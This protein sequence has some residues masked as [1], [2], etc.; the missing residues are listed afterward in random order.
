MFSL[1]DMCNCVGYFKVSCQVV[2]TVPKLSGSVTGIA[3]LNDRM[4]VSHNVDGQIA[5][6]CPAN[7]QF[8]QY[9]NCYCSSCRKRSGYI[10]QCCYPLYG[11]GYTLELQHV[12]A[13]D[14]N[15][16]LYISIQ[17]RYNGNRICKVAVDQNNKLFC[18]FVHGTIPQCLSVTSSG[19]VLVAVT[20]A[21]VMQEYSQQGQLIRQTKLQPAGITNPIHAVQLSNDHFGVTHHG[22]KHQFSI[23]NSDGQLV[24]RYGSDAGDMSQPQQIAVDQRGRIFVAD[25]NNNR[26][27][28]I[29]SKTLSAYPLRLLTECE[30]NGPYSIHFDAASNRLYIG[31]WNGCR[32]HCCQL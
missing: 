32:I 16:C 25:Q 21:N 8:Q 11:Y 23:V 9:L 24:Q 13:C 10:S 28:V 26:I 5:V 7:F 20:N 6:Y 31:E 18:W 14:I 30:L 4:Y 19:N 3:V 2:H 29:D 17:D 12:V 15:N 27:L 22:P 1:F